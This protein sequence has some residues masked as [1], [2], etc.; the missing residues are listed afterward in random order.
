MAW[1][2][3]FREWLSEDKAL[4]NAQ[5]VID[6]LYTDDKDWSKES[7]AGLL[8]NLRSE[9][10]VNP[11]MYEFGYS[12]QA[13]RGFG[14]V[15]WTP[16]TK[17][18]KWAEKNGYSEEEWRNGDA[19]LERIDYEVDNN[20]QYVPNGHEVRYGAGN[21]YDFSFADFRSNAHDL[22]VD[23]LTEAFMWNYEGPAYSA[24]VDSLSERQAFANKVNDQLNWEGGNSGGGDNG[25]DGDEPEPEFDF[26]NVVD[27]FQNFADNL[28]EKIE[29][30][31]TLNI[32]D[33][34][35]S[36]KSSNKFFSIDKTF[37]NLNKIRPTINFKEVMDDFIQSGMDQLNDILDGI[38]PPENGG[39]GDNGEEPEPPQ[40]D[41]PIVPMDHPKMIVTSEY[42]MRGGSLHAGID[43]GVAGNPINEVE[44]FATMNGT[45]KEVFTGCAS[46]GSWGCNA[47]AGNYVVIEHTDGY[48]SRY[49]HLGQN[50]IPLEEGQEISKGDTV[51]KMADSG[52]SQ[53]SHLHF[54]I[55]ESYPVED[56][57][58]NPRDYVD[59]FADVPAQT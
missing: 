50:S 43:I 34:Q 17:F 49:L 1:H 21:K 26:G 30:Y 28:I 58:I 18:V 5:L 57:T 10:S 31:L 33:Y 16:R 39:G 25:N 20:I 46:T 36:R 52:S 45:V 9:S 4:K 59:G 53:G 54:E 55:A 40:D 48:A 14:L 24:G 6:H 23:E 13:D 35:N 42:G 15:Q 8:G 44:V 27:F 22:S 19:Q 32:Y 37:P 51:G 7:I 56:N 29:D 41:E 47:G 2:N 3:E 12:W 38:T 11:N